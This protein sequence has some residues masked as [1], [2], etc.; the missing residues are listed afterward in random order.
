M[1][2]SLGSLMT[3]Q[4]LRGLSK[5]RHRVW[6]SDRQGLKSCIRAYSEHLCGRASEPVV[7]AGTT[8]ST[9]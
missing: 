6:H 4:T 5:L 3:Q 8:Q 2:Q 7:K 9:S 1:S